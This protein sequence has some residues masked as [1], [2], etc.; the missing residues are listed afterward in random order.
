MSVETFQHVG[1]RVELGDVALSKEDV[2]AFR[3]S[4]LKG[5]RI[6]EFVETDTESRFKTRSSADGIMTDRDLAADYDVAAMAFFAKGVALWDMDYARTKITFARYNQ[7]NEGVKIYNIYDVESFGGEPVRA[8]RLVRVIRN[9]S[10]L[11]FDETGEPVREK[12]DEQ[13]KAYEVQMTS[14]DVARVDE[15]VERITRRSLITGGH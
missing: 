5:A 15:L 6:T 12:Y 7:K 10:R 3:L 9:L 11:A 8:T 2:S 14:D 4:A 13:R 1:K